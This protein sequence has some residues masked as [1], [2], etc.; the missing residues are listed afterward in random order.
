MFPE[1]DENWFLIDTSVLVNIRDE[2]SDSEEIWAAVIAEVQAGRVKTVRQVL[3]ELEQ[4]FKPIYERLKPHKQ[5]LLV[6]DG[7]A[8]SNEVAAE[9]RAIHRDHIKLYNPIGG[10]NPADPFLIAVAKE[11]SKEHATAVVTD[12]RRSGARYRSKIPYVC[13]QRGV[14]CIDRLEFLKEIGIDV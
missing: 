8:Y 10:I 14:A 7:I 13:Q 6:A 4:K 1:D 3:D 5:D 9:I 11:L 12:E 2:H